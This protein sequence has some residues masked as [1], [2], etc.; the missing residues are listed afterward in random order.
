[1]QQL[2]R[3]VEADPA[4]TRSITG[5]AAN[6]TVSQGRIMINLKPFGDA[7]ASASE[8]LNA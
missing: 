6:P 1:M 5:S 2:G 4:V 3:I 8:V 7:D